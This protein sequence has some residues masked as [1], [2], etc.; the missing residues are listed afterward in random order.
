MDHLCLWTNIFVD[1]LDLFEVQ[2]TVSIALIWSIS[3]SKPLHSIFVL[4]FFFWSATFE[5]V[6]VEGTLV[7]T[8]SYHPVSRDL[9]RSFL[10]KEPLGTG[11]HAL[12]KLRLSS[13]WWSVAMAELIRTVSFWHF[14]TRSHINLIHIANL[15]SDTNLR[16]WSELWVACKRFA[17][18]L[19]SPWASSFPELPWW[20]APNFFWQSFKGGWAELGQIERPREFC[21][22]RVSASRGGHCHSQVALSKILLLCRKH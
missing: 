8:E 19:V 4:H 9:E 3:C 11:S 21:R 13:L 18:P 10:E 15:L 5:V 16:I 2:S 6:S 20:G 1:S 17:F 14:L 7:S 12:P 22:K